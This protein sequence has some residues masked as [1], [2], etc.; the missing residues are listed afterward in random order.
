MPSSLTKKVGIAALIMMASV[1]LSRVIGL[2]RNMVI[3]YIGGASGAVDAYQVAFIIPEILNHV[4]ASGFLSVTFIPIFSNYLVQNKEAEGWKV[5]SL[6][7]T[8]FGAMLIV[9][10][11]IAFIFAPQLVALTAPGL[12]DT[13]QIASAVRMTRIILP[14]QLFFFLGGMLMA[15][16]FTKERFKL[17]ALAPL[18]YT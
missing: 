9:L 7:V 8:T 3:G 2:L 10:I 5:F 16:Q 1:L 4:V 17:P 15:V 6:I 14:A 18:I 13:A 11:G 12:K